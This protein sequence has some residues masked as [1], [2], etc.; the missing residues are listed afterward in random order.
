[1]RYSYCIISVIFLYRYYILEFLTASA[2]LVNA[3]LVAFTGTFADGYSA[4][5]RVWIFVGISTGVLLLKYVIAVLIPDVPNDVS[6]QLKR[7]EFFHEKLRFQESPES[8][9]G[10]IQRNNTQS[11]ITIL[12]VDDDQ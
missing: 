3:G 9:L 6:I 8:R 1:M 11:T 12:A 5:L 2:V 7:A 10:E 4:A